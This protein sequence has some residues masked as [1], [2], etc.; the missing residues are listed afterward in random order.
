MA[1]ALTVPFACSTVLPD[2]LE[3]P[4]SSVLVSAQIFLCG[5]AIYDYPFETTPSLPHTFF[6]FSPKHPLPTNI[7]LFTS[8][9]LLPPLESPWERLFFYSWLSPL[10]LSH[11]MQSVNTERMRSESHSIVSDSLWSHGLYNPWGSSGQ[12]TG[13]GSLSLL[14]GI[15]P[16]RGSNPGL[17]HCLQILYQL[18]CKMNGYDLKIM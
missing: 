7:H 13:V 10:C 1:F 2:I 18:S 12:N 3:F 16:T 5:R 4:S 15:F 6:D 9:I 14:Q 17:P 11:C 8:V